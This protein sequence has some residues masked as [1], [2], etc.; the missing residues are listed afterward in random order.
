M[1]PL[2]KPETKKAQRE[3]ERLVSDLTEAQRAFDLLSASEKRAIVDALHAEQAALE[4]DSAQRDLSLLYRRVQQMA[5]SSAARVVKF[6][7]ELRYTTAPLHALGWSAGRFED[8]AHAEVYGEFHRML[9][10]AGP[11]RVYEYAQDQLVSLARGANNYSTS[12]TGN[13]ADAARLA[14]VARFIDDLRWHVGGSR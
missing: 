13:L 8:A 14:S 11:F 5:E 1:S 3:R 12:P 9:L 6:A 2:A 10:L 7:E 4:A